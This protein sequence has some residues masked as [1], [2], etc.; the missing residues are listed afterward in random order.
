MKTNVQ[1]LTEG[2]TLKTWE[3]WVV[4]E[5][6]TPLVVGGSSSTSLLTVASPEEVGEG[7]RVVDLEAA[8]NF[9]FDWES[10]IT[11]DILA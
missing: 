6:S 2:R 11:P 1:D 10:H 4:V 3:A 7:F 9:I 5:V 8:T